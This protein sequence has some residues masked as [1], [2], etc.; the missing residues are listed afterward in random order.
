MH[1]RL[2]IYLAFIF[3][4]LNVSP[5]QLFVI[6]EEFSF[7]LSQ[8][9]HT[10]RACLI[11]LI[12]YDIKSLSPNED[13]LMSMSPGYFMTPVADKLPIALS[14][15]LWIQDFAK[16]LF[17]GAPTG[18]FCN[19]KYYNLAFW[20]SEFKFKPYFPPNQKCSV[21]VHIILCNK[22]ELI[23][24]EN[25]LGSSFRDLRRLWAPFSFKDMIYQF[26]TTPDVPL[27]QFKDGLFQALV[28]RNIERDN[29]FQWGVDIDRS[30]KF[31]SGDPYFHPPIVAN[32]NLKIVYILKGDVLE[33]DPVCDFEVYMISTEEQT[34]EIIKQVAPTVNQILL[35]KV[36]NFLELQAIKLDHS[37]FSMASGKLVWQDLT[38]GYTSKGNHG[39]NKKKTYG[40]LE[41]IAGHSLT[42][43][44]VSVIARNFTC[45]LPVQVLR[46]TYELGDALH[47][48][49]EIAPNGEFAISDETY[50]SFITCS[51]AAQMNRSFKELFSIYDIQTWMFLIITC[52]LTVAVIII[53]KRSKILN[54]GNEKFQNVDVAMFPLRVLLEQGSNLPD[55]CKSIKNRRVGRILSNFVPLWLLLAIVLSNGYRGENI[56]RLIA[57]IKTQLINKFGQLIEGKYTIYSTNMLDTLIGN[58]LTDDK[59]H[60]MNKTTLSNAALMQMRDSVLE[61]IMPALKTMNGRVDNR[62]L[63][64][65]Y[66]PQ[67][68]ETIVDWQK[69]VPKSFNKAH[70]LFYS[71]INLVYFPMTLAE[72]INLMETSSFLERISFCNS[73]ALAMERH[74]INLV[75]NSFILDLWNKNKSTQS[76]KHVSVGK[77][78]FFHG[79]KGFVPKGISWPVEKASK[80]F[81]M[82]DESGV[83]RKF[84]KWREWIHTHQD[85]ARVKQIEMEERVK[86]ISLQDN[87]HVVFF[88]FLGFIALDI[89]CLQVEVAFS[90]KQE[91]RN[92]PRH[93][94]TLKTQ[95]KL[96]QKIKRT[97]SI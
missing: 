42:C 26:R 23:P 95:S 87:I 20:E 15:H 25:S 21:Q 81:R 65:L 4:I 57:P 84:V 77:D 45:Q 85:F 8:I 63:E 51:G 43:T 52:F 29:W 27:A 17:H 36:E 49:V 71:L 3:V 69:R 68:Y 61:Y 97:V 46:G 2:K 38:R 79:R 55:F 54:T 22:W 14:R 9:L 47:L 89:I 90:K 34:W 56:G 70:S 28:T 74:E 72:S 53:M 31:R 1:R 44:L 40:F 93:F 60:R 10:F 78:E 33:S 94:I 12:E 13:V 32:D 41:N 37:L 86:R 50:M 64:T 30:T 73:T 24:L 6:N 11:H 80:Q 48:G 35:R 88:L 75:K 5:I 96:F 83:S 91:I 82:L 62:I 92:M 67:V 16:D 39:A 7:D 66:L 58:M 18:L 19:R 76:W 59:G